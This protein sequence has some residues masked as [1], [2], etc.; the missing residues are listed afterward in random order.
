MAH[1]VVRLRHHAA[2]SAVVMP[3]HSRAQMHSAAVGR[4][5]GRGISEINLIYH[6]NGLE[7][8]FQSL[9][10]DKRDYLENL[11]YKQIAATMMSHETPR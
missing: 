9:S 4:F 3:A 6:D 2:V 11:F 7:G 1:T 10:K 8:Y 5:F